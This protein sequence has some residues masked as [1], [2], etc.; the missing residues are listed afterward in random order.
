LQRQ[1]DNAEKAL[2]TNPQYA[3]EIMAGIVSR[4]PECLEARKLLRK[5]QRLVHGGGAAGG[6][7]KLFGGLFGGG[8]IKDAESAR[9]AIDTAE[10][11]LAQNP[12]DIAANKQLAAAGEKLGWFDLAAFAYESL[13]IADPKNTDYFASWGNALLKDENYDEAIKVIDEGLKRFPGNGD[14]QEIARRASV[15]KTVKK[16]N[17]ENEGDFKS[18]AKDLGSA[19][20]LDNQSRIVQDAEAAARIVAELEQKIAADPENVDYYREAVKNYLVL[21][22][23]SS[24]IRTLQ[25]ARET[26]L[27]RADAALEKHENELN[28]QLYD[29]QVAALKE[30]TE[31]DP[32]NAE[33]RGQYEQLAAN[34]RAYRLQVYQDLVDRYPNDYGYRY[35]LGVLLYENDRNDD[36]IQQLQIAQRNPK[37]RHSAMLYLARA[38][39]RGGK[40]DLAVDQLKDAR[41]ELPVMSDIKKEIIYELAGAY[42]KLGKREEALDEYKSIYKV[43]ASYK[44]VADKINQFYA[45]Q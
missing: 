34:A 19:A 24:A 29:Q 4:N 8:K 9:K 1:A 20:A 16:G 42:E 5:A 32:Q 21:N 12:N 11:K 18:K 40:F 14:L 15:Q 22:D 31:A 6:L 2:R 17:W 13:V 43:D 35:N 39:I 44:D 7:G 3:A 36:A 45:K 37:N 23:L 33:L 38:F 25:R 26:N 30:Q 41:G 27:G 10:Q 28:M